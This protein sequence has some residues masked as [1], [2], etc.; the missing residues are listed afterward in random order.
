MENSKDRSINDTLP[1]TYLYYIWL[2]DHI[3]EEQEG[4][5]DVYEYVDE[6]D[7]DEDEEQQL[8]VGLIYITSMV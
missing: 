4:E 1:C 2:L 7:S 5:G 3:V 8:P 6:G